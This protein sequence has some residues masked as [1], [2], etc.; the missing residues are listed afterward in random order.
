MQFSP[1]F[2][3]FLSHRSKCYPQ[4]HVLRHCVRTCQTERRKKED[5]LAKSRAEIAQSVHWLATGWT[6]RSGFDSR[7]DLGIF[8]FATASRPVLGP[9][10]S[11][12]PMGTRVLSPCINAAGMWYH[13]PP[14][15][16]EVKN[17]S[18]YTSSP[19][20]TFTAWCLVKHRDF[21]FAWFS[22]SLLNKVWY[23]LLMPQIVSCN[24]MFMS[25]TL[26][27]LSAQTMNVQ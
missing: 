12:Y 20:Y 7:Q 3:H 26:S 15:S 17:M 25:S 19:P 14:S 6:G 13:S 23:R 2:W 22:P 11:P 1:A 10:Q 4:R 8:L 21:T 5:N 16:A 18:S 24:L 9:T 27:S